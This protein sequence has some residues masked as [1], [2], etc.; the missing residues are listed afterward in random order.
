MRSIKWVG[1]FVLACALGTRATAG[2]AYYVA[3]EDPAAAEANPG[4]EKAPFKTLSNAC[5]VARAGDTVY[6]KKGVYRE[7]LIPKHSGT[8]RRPIV[9]SGWKND[10]VTIKGSEVVGGFAR[11]GNL[12]VKRPW[13]KPDYYW[14]SEFEGISLA[15]FRSSGRIQQIFVNGQLLQW[16]PTPQDLKPGCFFW[17]SHKTAGGELL[18][19]PPAGLDDP[20]KALIETPS[21]P[22]VVGA[23]LGDPGG[24]A[25]VRWY[26]M[27]RREKAK[28][29]GKEEEKADDSKF[30]K[31]DFIHIRNL[32]FRHGLHPLNRAGVRL[33]GDGWLLEN[34]RV[35]YMSSIG[36]VVAGDD[37]V[38]RNCVIS[39]NGQCG[40]NDCYTRNALFENCVTMYNNTRMFSLSW[41]GAGNK[42]IAKTH[43]NAIR[44]LVSCFNYG[45]GLWHDWDCNEI[46][47]EDCLSLGN[48]PI[49]AGFFYEVSRGGLFARNIAFANGDGGGNFYGAALTLSSSANVI[50][51]DNVFFGSSGGVAIGGG[52]RG[53][54]NVDPEWFVAT[55]NL[56]RKNLMVDG[57]NFTIS[58]TGG[59]TPDATTIEAKNRFR[60][61]TFL[62]VRGKAGAILGNDTL[63]DPTELDKKYRNASGNV[64][65][66]D[67]AGLDRA[68]RRKLNAAL[69]RILNVLPLAD[70]GPALKV[71]KAELKAI[72]SLGAHD[73]SFG[74]WIDADGQF[75]LMLYTPKADTLQLLTASDKAELWDF[76]PLEPTLRQALKRNGNIAMASVN[77]PFA[78]ITGLD[79]RALPLGEL[80]KLSARA[81]GAPVREIMEGQ[82]FEVAIELRNVLPEPATFTVSGTG[83]KGKSVRIEAGGRDTL[84]VALVADAVG[85]PVYQ[86]ACA[87]GVSFSRTVDMQVYKPM[88]LPRV[89]A[90][91]CGLAAPPNILYGGL[92]ELDKEIYRHKDVCDLRTGRSWDGPKDLAA[93]LNVAWTDAGLCLTARVVDNFM[94]A[95]RNAPYDGDCIE[96]FLD[97]RAD[98]LGDKLY[99]TGCYQVFC[100][101]PVGQVQWQP[102]Q[103]LCPRSKTGIAGR[104]RNTAE[105]YEM[106]ILLDWALFPDFKAVKGSL[107]G[108]DF[109]ID[110]ADEAKTRKT[111]LVWKG[112]GQ[113]YQDASRFG[114]VVLDQP[115]TIDLGTTLRAGDV[116]VRT[117]GQKL[118]VYR[119]AQGDQPVAVVPLRIDGQYAGTFSGGACFDAGGNLYF[120]EGP[121]NQRLHRVAAGQSVSTVLCELPPSAHNVYLYGA[122]LLSPGTGQLW[123]VTSDGTLRVLKIGERATE[124][125]QD[126]K[127]VV[128][129]HT[130]SSALSADGKLAA[131]T[132]GDGDSKK[133]LA[134]LQVQP[135]EELSTIGSE[136]KLFEYIVGLTFVEG[137]Q[138]FLAVAFN[139]FAPGSTSHVARVDFDAATGK[140]LPGAGKLQSL[141]EAPGRLNAMVFDRASGKILLTWQKTGQPTAIYTADTAALAAGGLKAE[142]LKPFLATH[143]GARSI[144]VAPAVK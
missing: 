19:Y 110:D 71:R 70:G 104:A 143:E 63:A 106:E 74:Y 53:V 25:G 132:S 136:S 105:G 121:R 135:I 35:E 20:D 111:Q 28:Q 38:V 97:G 18:V 102:L 81:Q 109:A 77:G 67:V 47:V 72:W 119:P 115:V 137:P 79:Q 99:S 66:R 69:T 129:G 116:V 87:G 118:A 126:V 131:L 27:Q 21:I 139:G 11:E 9:F 95:N 14:D 7:A 59:S 57:C 49:N 46:A 3:G 142:D 31:I 36:V 32:G 75:I 39:H 141:F 54:P 89:P 85:R 30:P 29:A 117:G 84:S 62:V 40:F 2:E 101:A 55:N 88:G 80:M 65:I 10:A 73:G 48:N 34:C 52:I 13:V 98:K 128:G 60:D 15:P 127:A 45:S 41:A 4:T 23:W 100:I 61:N 93:R 68:S 113:N 108:L 24:A 6:I 1:T 94:Y 122:D 120:L 107:M 78:I 124:L 12:W 22:N 103:F 50:A 96:I 76:P 144:A 58:L 112:T 44:G 64:V 26:A 92:I 130:F 16:V 56:I 83:L 133:G 86:L 138:P 123:M 8:K 125:V 82:P 51:E 33:D 114:R 91:D 5:A 140:F 90:F 42:C 134:M 43:G 37:C 17:K